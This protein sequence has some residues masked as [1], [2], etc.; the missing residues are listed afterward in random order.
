MTSRSNTSFPPSA[1]AAFGSRN[2]TRAEF[3]TM[4]Q[5]AFS[6]R[7]GPRVTPTFDAQ[8]SSAFG[9]QQRSAAVANF[10]ESAAT[11]FG[12]HQRGT[13]VGGFDERA[14]SAF[15]SSD[16]RVSKSG[17]DERASSAFGKKPKRE[18]VEPTGPPPVKA[19]SFAAHISLAL[20][21]AGIVTTRTGS[22][23]FKKKK[24]EAAPVK[25]MEEMFPA[26]SSAPTQKPAAPKMSFAEIMKK[27]VEEEAI[28]EKQREEAA[29]AAREERRREE[30]DA[31]RVRSVYKFTRGSASNKVMGDEE[32]FYD[33][34]EVDVRPEDREPAGHETDAAHEEDEVY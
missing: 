8:A 19:N 24:E 14:S 18:P 21:E 26:L 30:R 13:A 9:A 2:K 3:D 27:R 16:R 1:S 15:D 34:G 32:E 11:A 22:A 25:T 17:F 10:S 4:A 33:D 5:T 12:A 20:G 23:L 28:I 6:R 31:Y 7:A 29:E